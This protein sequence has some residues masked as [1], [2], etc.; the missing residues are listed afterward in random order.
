MVTITIYMLPQNY[1]SRRKTENIHQVPI[2]F[3]KPGRTRFD[4]REVKIPRDP[5]IWSSPTGSH[6]NKQDSYTFY[7][8]LWYCLLGSEGVYIY[9][10][11]EWKKFPDN[12]ATSRTHTQQRRGGECVYA[13]CDTQTPLYRHGFNKRWREWWRDDRVSHMCIRWLFFF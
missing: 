11:L 13:C 1:H 5:G 9:C 12:F 10:Y 4:R 7:E 2:P 3:E 8:M 6:S